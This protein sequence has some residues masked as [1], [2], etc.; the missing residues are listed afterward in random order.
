MVRSM[1]SIWR[2]SLVVQR[3]LSR[4]QHLEKFR[5]NW[6][7][8]AIAFEGDRGEQLIELVDRLE[9]VEIAA[10]SRSFLVPDTGMPESS[11]RLSKEA[12]TAFGILMA[13]FVLSGAD[14]YHRREV[15]SGIPGMAAE[16]FLRRTHY[17]DDRHTHLSDYVLGNRYRLRSLWTAARQPYGLYRVRQQVCCH[18]YL[19]R[20][21]LPCL[22]RLC[23]PPAIELC[24]RGGDATGLRFHLHLH[25]A[26]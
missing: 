9:D 3:S 21:P 2:K 12:E 1:P 19:Y 18:S 20:L 26:F 23:G 6:K 7:S 11:T 15:V 4:E 16:R 8:G 17:V 10:R 13:E 24:D 22:A 14:Q 5:E 25:R